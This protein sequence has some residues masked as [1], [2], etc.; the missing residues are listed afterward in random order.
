M[1]AAIEKPE[2]KNRQENV[3]LEQLAERLNALDAEGWKCLERFPQPFVDST[4][5]RTK[6]QQIVLLLIRKIKPQP[7]SV[8]PRPLKLWSVP[9]P[10]F[11]IAPAAATE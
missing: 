3:D 7:A 6:S 8:T 5:K 9:P 4:G 10:P 1:E 2:G 11:Q